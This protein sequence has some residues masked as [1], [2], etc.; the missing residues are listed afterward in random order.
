[1]FDKLCFEG[2]PDL[3]IQL[4][5]ENSEKRGRVFSSTEHRGDTFAPQKNML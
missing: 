3:E 5:I 2:K 4:G 1:M